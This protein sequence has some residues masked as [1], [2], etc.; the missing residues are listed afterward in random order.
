MNGYWYGWKLIGAW[1][2]A[3]LGWYLV[4]QG[5]HFAWGTS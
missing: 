4:I 3:S 5:A 2:V 1:A